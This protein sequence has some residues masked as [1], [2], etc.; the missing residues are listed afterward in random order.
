M[1]I[2]RFWI[3]ILVCSGLLIAFVQ[4]GCGDNPCQRAEPDTCALIP[5]TASNTCV[6]S[7]NSDEDFACKCCNVLDGDPCDPPYDEQGRPNCY[8]WIEPDH[9]CRKV[10]PDRC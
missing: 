6:L 9:F 3:P 5:N 10:N 8:Q 1:K 7:A 4:S 2:S